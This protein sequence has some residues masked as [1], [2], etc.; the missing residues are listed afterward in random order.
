MRPGST[1]VRAKRVTVHAPV[2]SFRHPFFVVGTQPTFLFPPPSTIHGH[3]A[4]AL[5][6]FPDPQTFWFGMHFTFRARARDLEHQHIAEAAG[7]RRRVA[8]DD[9]T[10]VAASTEATVQPVTR[11]FLFDARL[12]LYL[13][14]EHGEA[15][16]S[17]A[18]VMTLGR[19]QDLATV[20]SIEDVTLEKVTRARLE[21]TLLPRSVRPAVRFGPTVLMTRHISEPPE[22]HATFAQYIALHEPVFFG[23]PTKGSRAFD[24]VD[25][26]STEDLLCDPSVQDDEGF[27]RG[28]WVHR[29]VDA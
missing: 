24:I 11:E 10:D 17:P 25:G 26:V 1:D 12:T 5:G 7:A 2:T 29:L 18:H 20:V 9:G 16:A 19:S 8:L 3:C 4:S 27:A 6:S 22:R 23:D 13:A 14:P 21:H 15:F 28:V